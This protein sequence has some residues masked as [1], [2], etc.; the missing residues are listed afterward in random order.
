LRVLAADIGGTT[1]R[2]ACVDETGAIL[3]RR[4]TETPQD[5]AAG[6]AALRAL[7]HELGPADAA[8]LVVPGG[9]RATT[10]E[11]TQSPNLPQWEGTRPGAE[12]SCAALNDANGSLLGE[13]WLGALRGRRSAVL[14]TL[15]T[16]VGGAVMIDGA[17]WT[18]AAGCAGEIGHM[19]VRP[20]GPRCPCGSRGCLE[21]YASAHAV[22][23]WGGAHDAKH[24][25]ELARQREPRASGAFQRA[26]ESLGIALAGVAN[27]LNPEV[28]CIGGGLSAAFDLFKEPLLAELKA[29]AFDLATEHVAVL[30]AALGGDAGLLGAARLA[31]DSTKE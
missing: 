8:G 21:L 16:G 4:E 11:I 20:D 23:K 22:A 31:L 3:D 10:G 27:L 1:I 29:R 9:I 2:A 24:A 12:L 7:F 17:L 6:Y 19:S 28:F 13:A 15:G 30:P 14:L 26:G 5:P 25:A 18:G